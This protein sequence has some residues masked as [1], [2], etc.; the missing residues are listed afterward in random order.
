MNT[1]GWWYFGCTRVHL[2]GLHTEE[3]TTVDH[4]EIYYYDGGERTG[5]SG[6]D[7]WKEATVTIEKT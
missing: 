2:T 7:S 1:G 3:R 5:G 6:F 4:K